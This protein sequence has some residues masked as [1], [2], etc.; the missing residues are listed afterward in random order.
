MRAFFMLAVDRRTVCFYDSRQVSITGGGIMPYGLEHKFNIHARR[1]MDAY[2]ENNLKG[3]ADSSKKL[4]AP[5]LDGLL[6]YVCSFPR[7][8][9]TLRPALRPMVA[10]E[11]VFFGITR[12]EVTARHDALRA[13]NADVEVFA[14]VDVILSTGKATAEAMRH[15]LAITEKRGYE[16][17][18]R[19]LHFG[20]QQIPT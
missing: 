20:L 9:R 19:A 8:E 1:A 7:A 13:V 17:A 10:V 14:A 2:N 5:Y 11:A 18:S 15:A 3:F 4:D 16:A 12:A 6:E